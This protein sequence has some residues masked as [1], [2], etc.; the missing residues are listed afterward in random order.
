MKLLID[1]NLSPR[2]CDVLREEKVDSLHWSSVGSHSATDREIMQWALENSFVVLTHDLD[3]GAILA[4]TRATG[5][6]VIQVRTQD[7]RPEKLATMLY[8]VLRNFDNEIRGG[9]LL[10]V[11]PSR[12]RVRSLPLRK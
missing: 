5:P 10:I 8:P 1:M 7:V 11:D 12:A 6:S 2:L 3:F 4:A 9:A